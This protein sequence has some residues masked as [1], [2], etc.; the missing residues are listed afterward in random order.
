MCD[1]N[2]IKRLDLWAENQGCLINIRAL[3]SWEP[4]VHL[5]QSLSCPM[6]VLSG[7]LQALKSEKPQVHPFLSLPQRLNQTLI[8]ALEG[9]QKFASFRDR[10]NPG[11]SKSSNDF[12]I[13]SSSFLEF[14]LTFVPKFIEIW[15]CYSL[16]CWETKVHFVFFLES[17]L[18]YGPKFFQ[19]RA[20]QSQ[21]P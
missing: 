10:Q 15:T 2:P 1:I 20:S 3:E 9:Q 4:K 19:A 7:R 6:F 8:L 12:E 16:S 17:I 21:K 14:F 11:P 5:F 13:R 18:M